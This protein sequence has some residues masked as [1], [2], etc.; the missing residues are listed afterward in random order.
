MK[1][2]LL[3]FLLLPTACFAQPD[4]AMPSG[5]SMAVKFSLSSPFDVFNFPTIDLSVEHKITNRFSL[6]AEGGYE[7]YRFRRPDTVFVK[8]SGYELNG[9]FR[10]YQPFRWRTPVPQ[11]LSGFYTGLTFFYRNERFNSSVDYNKGG[12]TTMMYTD[13][14]WTEKNAAG[15]DLTLGYQ[16]LFGG[17]GLF[18]LYAGIGILRRDIYH[19]ELQYSEAN[20]D[21][22]EETNRIDSFFARRNLDEESGPGLSLTI[23]FRVG[24]IIY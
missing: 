4:T 6:M 20:G 10:I 17:R 3:L 23:G 15:V 16:K 1:R 14:Y 11:G 2:F 8:Q 13:Y 12:D 7:F 18:D 5:P 24:Y 9:G 19:N 22:I 21:V